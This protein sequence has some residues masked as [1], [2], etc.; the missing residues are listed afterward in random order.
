MSRLEVEDP[1]AA[2]GYLEN[3]WTNVIPHGT[4]GAPNQ[5][6]RFRGNP[7]QLLNPDAVVRHPVRTAASFGLDAVFFAQDFVQRGRNFFSSSGSIVQRSLEMIDPSAFVSREPSVQLFQTTVSLEHIRRSRRQLFLVTTN[8]QTGQPEYFKNQHMTDEAGLQ[9]IL[10]SSAIPGIF[11]AV[12]IAGKVYVDGGLSLNT[13]LAPTFVFATPGA[14]IAHVI[15]LDPK[16]EDIPLQP[17]QSAIGTMD[18]LIVIGLSKAVDSD[19]RIASRVNRGLQLVAQPARVERLAPETVSVL[20]RSASYLVDGI[21]GK[22][23]DSPKTIHRYRPSRYLGGTMSL[24]NFSREQMIL[25]VE[26]GFSVVMN[27]DC[28]ASACVLPSG[29]TIEA[30]PPPA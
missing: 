9:I 27:H 8:W 11:P 22:L 5:V 26:L 20:L 25:L 24:L 15:Y 18:R 6:Y 7:A 19:M 28:K 13:P 3:V 23:P 16:T 14:D 4:D 30:L 1:A 10:A 2:I 17:L 12:T 21:G 29:P